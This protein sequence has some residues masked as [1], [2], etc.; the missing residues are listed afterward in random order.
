MKNPN[1]RNIAILTALSLTLVVI[2]LY[3][4]VTNN[5]LLVIGRPLLFLITSAFIVYAFIEYFIFR[6]IK[7][8]YKTIYNL[9]S[10]RPLSFI[11]TLKVNNPINEVDQEVISWAQSK[12]TEIENLKRLEE[13]RKEFLGNVSHE[14]K[15]P[16]F[17][18]QGYIHTLLDGA[19]DDEENRIRFLNKAAKSADR[20]EEL[21]RDLMDISALET[22]G[23][24]LNFESFDIVELVKDIF[25]SL[26]LKAKARGMT[27]A[28]KD[29]MRGSYYVDADKKSIRQVLVNLIVN[30][31]KYGNVG[32]HT[33]VGF[34]DMHE[35]ILIEVSDNGDGIAPEHLPRLFERFYRIDKARSRDDGG[36]GLGLSIV[37]HIVEAHGQTLN[38]RSKESLG[39]T[40][41]FTLR[42]TKVKLL[43]I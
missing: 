16:I 15:T 32:G 33:L 29:G 4:P 5:A 37:K 22:G 13:Y 40:F 9:K 36:T 41:G 2:G 1:P 39:S 6:K 31:V 38:V 11:S 14:L 42:K 17:N 27:L 18:L 7:V 20:L 30:S 28:L 3:W 12:V 34:Y 35:N 24:N 19:I 10:N 43:Q 23:V 8:I 21:V 26:E 25:E